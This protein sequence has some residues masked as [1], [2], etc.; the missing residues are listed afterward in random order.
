MD[1]NPSWTPPPLGGSSQTAG[2]LGQWNGG[3]VV[4]DAP[5]AKGRK[6]RKAAKAAPDSRAHKGTTIDDGA[7]AG[8][9][10]KV[11]S[12]QR[13][14]AIGFAALAVGL[15][16][17]TTSSAGPE[18]SFV[19]RTVVP[20]QSLTPLT[21][22][23]VEGFEI[24]TDAIEPGALTGATAEEAVAAV[25]DTY[26]GATVRL[27]MAQFEQLHEDDL[28]LEDRLRIAIAD[29]QALVSFNASI[30]RAVG[31][32]LR[33]GDFVDVIAVDDQSGMANVLVSRAEVVDVT[34]PEDAFNAV[35]Q[36]QAEAGNLD[37][38]PSDFLPGNP[39]PG[40]Y[41]LLVNAVDAP[42]LTL[43]QAAASVFLVYRA[44]GVATAPT[45]P[46]SLMAVMCGLDIPGLAPSTIEALPDACRNDSGQF[47][48]RPLDGVGDS[49]TGLAVVAPSGQSTDAEEQSTDADEQSTD[50]SSE[51]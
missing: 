30:A 33:V 23:M 27:P 12:S 24:Q 2:D 26:I 32:D 18:T 45:G 40:T 21:A 37:K 35:V 49:Q 15:F 43:A 7:G 11:L 28:V 47:D 29:G 48:Y 3:G 8:A 22:A 17:V 6:A 50:S 20:I 42:R 19:V 51:D 44:P 9:T 14:R 5:A 1:N 36:S 34:V 39:V 25:L 31:G 16:L 10:R 46:I 4:D 13:K 41:T 38:S